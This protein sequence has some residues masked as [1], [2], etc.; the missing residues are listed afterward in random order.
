M[1]TT[2][3]TE[4]SAGPRDT[5]LLALASLVV[6]ASLVAYYYFD[7][8]PTVI[9][10][11]GILVSLG[12]GVALVYS[13]Q[14]GKFL[15]QFIQGSRVEIRKVIWPTRP[16][17]TQTTLAVFAFVIIFGTFFWVLDFALL[18]MTRALTGQGG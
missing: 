12:V 2:K 14:L 15:W 11:L 5:I 1:A 4:A 9:R 7:D 18:F 17:T 13:T 8:T 16:E 10:V 3:E 6:L